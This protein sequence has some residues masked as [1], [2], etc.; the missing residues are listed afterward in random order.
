MDLTVTRY[1][2]DLDLD[3]LDDMGVPREKIVW[4]LMPGYHDAANEY[5][6]IDDAKNATYWAKEWGLA[7]VMTWDIN[8]DTEQRM[9]YAKGDDNLYQTGQPDGTYLDTLSSE[10]NS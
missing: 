7:G 5:T 3:L 6:S 1:S 8:R 2:F 10:I 4:G 9:D